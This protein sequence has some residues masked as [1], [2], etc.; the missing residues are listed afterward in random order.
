[1]YEFV[2]ICHAV[3]K[4]NNMMEKTQLYLGIGIILLEKYYSTATGNPV[5]IAHSSHT[6]TH[7]HA[8]DLKHVMINKI[9]F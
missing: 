4:W 1:M 8:H 5:H 3:G 7:L 2:C 6:H 9:P